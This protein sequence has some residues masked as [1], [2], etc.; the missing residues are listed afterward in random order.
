MPHACM[1]NLIIAN[2]QRADMETLEKTKE[3]PEVPEEGRLWW[4]EEGLYRILILGMVD[5]LNHKIP[6]IHLKVWWIIMHKALEGQGCCYTDFYLQI[7]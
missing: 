5:S 7:A 3:H 2:E 6:K 1:C 4:A